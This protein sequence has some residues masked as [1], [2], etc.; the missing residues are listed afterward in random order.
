MFL[1]HQLTT[2]LKVEFGLN[3]NYMK[4]RGI[5]FRAFHIFKA[6]LYLFKF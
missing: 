6:H 1:I 3:L 5:L 4:A 2:L